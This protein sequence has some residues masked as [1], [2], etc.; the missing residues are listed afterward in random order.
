[1]DESRASLS[2]FTLALALL[3]VVGFL[4]VD[5]LLMTITQLQYCCVNTLA[6]NGLDS[7]H[8]FHASQVLTQGIKLHTNTHAMMEETI[9]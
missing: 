6:A 4:G 2:R 7:T 1:M 5:T 3:A 8:Q 9:K